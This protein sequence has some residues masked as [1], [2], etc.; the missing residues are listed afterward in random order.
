MSSSVSA[1]SSLVSLAMR[2]MPTRMMSCCALKEMRSSTFTPSLRLKLLPE[3]DQTGRRVQLGLQLWQALLGREEQAELGD[4]QT[5][6]MDGQVSAAALSALPS[7][8]SWCR[9]RDSGQGQGLE[10][11]GRAREGQGGKGRVQ[12]RGTGGTRGRDKRQGP[13]AE[14]EGRS[15]PGSG[16]G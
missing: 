7:R 10:G 8:T 11:P 2:R 13:E 3:A 6:G 15:Q 9:R 1:I 14:T 12:R 5:A 4:D 16:K